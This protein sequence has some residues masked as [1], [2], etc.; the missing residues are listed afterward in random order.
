MKITVQVNDKPV[1][2]DLTADQVAKV[3]K[4]TD[5][6]TDR[7]KTFQDACEVLGYA[8][9]RSMHVVDKLKVIAEALNEDWKPD[10]QNSNQYKYVP[11]FIYNGM[12]FVF[13]FYSHWYSCASVGSRLCFK[14]AELD[15][16]C[17]KQFQDLY[18]EF[19]N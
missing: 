16:Y 18:N 15:E 5:K 3:K 11:Y 7:I 2:I 8:I 10:W 6:I 13:Y 1:E 14:S 19:L 17:A 9:P 4:H 12:A